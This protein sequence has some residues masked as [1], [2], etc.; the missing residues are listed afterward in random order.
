MG[1]LGLEQLLSFCHG[2]A[3][4]IPQ[5]IHGIHTPAVSMNGGLPYRENHSEPHTGA[6][7]RRE[8]LP[9]QTRG[10]GWDHLSLGSGS[11]CCL[12]IARNCL[13][14]CS[15]RLVFVDTDGPGSPGASQP[16]RP[17]KPVDL[18]LPEPG[19]C[20]VP[21]AS[22]LLP[23]AAVSPPT[24]EAPGPARRPISLQGPLLCQAEQQ[25]SSCAER[26]VLACG[27][28]RPTVFTSGRVHPES[29]GVTQGGAGVGP[30]L[31]GGQGCGRGRQRGPQGGG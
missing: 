24:W 23:G 25:V 29:Q 3:P 5:F 12:E 18:A 19:P 4:E 16:P 20:C 28:S 6:G 9:P 2:E 21:R 14:K 10:P 1:I 8:D 26:D 7:W 11:G 27:P 17:R 15:S 13:G 22:C 31:Q 30:F